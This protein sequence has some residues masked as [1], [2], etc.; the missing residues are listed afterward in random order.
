MMK[1]NLAISSIT[2]AAAVAMA[3]PVLGNSLTQAAWQTDGNGQTGWHFT[4]DGDA[5]PS[6]GAAVAPA[7][8]VYFTARPANNVNSSQPASVPMMSAIVIPAR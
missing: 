5:Y 6:T 1:R 8:P 4:G 2:L 7:T 3:L